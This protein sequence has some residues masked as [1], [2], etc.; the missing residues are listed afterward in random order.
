MRQFRKLG[1][2]IGYALHAR[3]GEIGKLKQVYFDDHYWSI[4]Y[5]IAHTGGWLV[6]HDVLIAPVAVIS[7]DIENK[8][9]EIDLTREQIKNAPSISTQLPVSQH[10]QQEYYRYYGWEPYWGG[11]P[12]IGPAPY[13]PPLADEAPG[14]PRHPHLRSSDEVKGYL[15]HARDGEIGH[16]EDFILEDP[17]WAVR[18]L[19]TDTR[20]WLPGKQVLVAP[21]W[22]QQVVWSQQE[23]KVDLAR[24]TIQ[25]APPYDNATIIDREYQAALYR[26]YGMEYAKD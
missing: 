8:R 13:L 25:T 1:D 14:E 22:I 9:L 23:V 24:E 17:G 10:F 3:D 5:F 26:H 21:A 18:Y 20:R 16:V 15:I 2:L 19:V 11:E 12:M 4:R 6:G 7:V